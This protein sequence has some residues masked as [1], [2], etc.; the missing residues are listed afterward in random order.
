MRRIQRDVRHEEMIKT[1]TSGE[2]PVF[3]EIW[4]LMLFAAA[5][6]IARGQRKPLEKVDSGKAIPDSYFSSPG[7]RG[8]LYLLGVA[9]SGDS[10]CLRGTE[11]AQDLL[12]NEFEEY[13]NGGL[14]EIAAR[15]S[16]SS[17][18]LDEFVSLAL[19]ATAT[20]SSSPNLSDLI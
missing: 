16:I 2:T 9:E 6:G 15:L 18:Q 5:L 10:N 12:V 13:A 19:E 11:A 4:R 7:W 20:R 8:F 1:L 3:R 17:V 14:D